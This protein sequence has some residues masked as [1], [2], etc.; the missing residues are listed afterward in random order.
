[1]RNVLAHEYGEI[2]YEVVWRAATTGLPTL[3]PA[4]DELVDEAR[5]IA[6]L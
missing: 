2:D 4:L 1:M 3:I 6:G 5:D